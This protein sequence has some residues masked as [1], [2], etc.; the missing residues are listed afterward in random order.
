MFWHTSIGRAQEFHEIHMVRG[1]LEQV[2]CIEVVEHADFASS[3]FLK[4][5]FLE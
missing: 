1:P 5:N 3:S 4:V 2:H